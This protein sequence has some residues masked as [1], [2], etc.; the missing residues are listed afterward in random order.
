MK[1]HLLAH[2]QRFDGGH[3]RSFVLVQDVD[4]GI[5]SKLAVDVSLPF[6]LAKYSGPRPHQLPI[7]NGNYHGAFQ[8]FRVN[9]RYNLWAHP[10]MVTPFVALGVPS[11]DYIYFAHSAGGTDQRE[12]AFGAS[13][14]RSFEPVL[15]RVYAQGIYTFLIPEKVQGI[16]TYRSRLDWDVGYFP[17]RRLSI[18]SLGTLQI[19]HSGLSVG[20]GPGSLGDFPVRVPSN[21]V[22]AHH[23]QTA[24]ISFLNV[25]GGASLTVTK[26][27]SAFANLTTTVWGKN[28]H[29]ISVGEVVGISWSFR[30]PW[31]GAKAADDSPDQHESNNPRKTP[32]HVH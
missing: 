13:F 14:G 7:D 15:P 4:F 6:V 24:R 22:W 16:R 28:G 31:A 1:Y 26:S 20:D 32:T 12:Y 8:D 17:T 11:H 30:T 19:G 10:L 29:A 18:K 21:V 9:V 5:T 3:I 27:W 25:G 2:G 23:D